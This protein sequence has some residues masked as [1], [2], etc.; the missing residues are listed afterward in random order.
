MF[1]TLTEKYISD[2]VAYNELEDIKP[3]D[4]NLDV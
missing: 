2:D 4:H 3:L 1:K